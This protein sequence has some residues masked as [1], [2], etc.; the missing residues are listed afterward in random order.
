M[1]DHTPEPWR[2]EGG[3]RAEVLTKDGYMIASCEWA[4]KEDDI[5]DANAERIVDCV[6]ACAG[7]DPEA[8]P[9]LLAVCEVVVEASKDH[10]SLSPG[11][12][13]SLPVIIAA[14]R[15]AIDQAKGETT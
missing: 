4:Q 5:P 1:S 9:G 7:L 11:W 8:V 6:N 15:A 13:A 3:D 14:A 2:T 12:F 10:G